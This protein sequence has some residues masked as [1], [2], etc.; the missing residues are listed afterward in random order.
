MMTD[1]L[2][3]ELFLELPRF[4]HSSFPWISMSFQAHLR[5]RFF[6]SST[7]PSSNS[8]SSK[9]F[10]EDLL[11]DKGLYHA[12]FI[13]LRLHS[14]SHEKTHEYGFHLNKESYSLGND[15]WSE[16]GTHCVHE[17]ISNHH[18]HC[19][20]LEYPKALTQYREYKA[21]IKEFASG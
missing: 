5:F 1:Y 7:L 3:L 13:R 21:I 18:F 9:R 19:C 2:T 20:T 17:K 6:P 15:T 11:A 8:P 12:L 14:V 4:S 10:A 16:M